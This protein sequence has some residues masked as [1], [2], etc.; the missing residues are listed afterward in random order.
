MRILSIDGGGIRGVIPARIIERI[1]NALGNNILNKFDFFAGTST[2]GLLALAFAYGMQPEE[3]IRMYKDIGPA[4]FKD[5]PFDDFRD[6]KML[7]G[8]DYS[9]EP[10]RDMLQAM[11]GNIRLGDLKKRVLISSFDLD[12]G[13][14]PPD[15]TWKPKFF[16]NFGSGADLDEK[17]VDVAIRTAAAPL[18]FPTYQG[19]I[20][21]GVIANNPSMCAVAAALNNW[22]HE[23]DLTLLSLG[24]GGNPEYISGENL[25]WGL[26]QWGASLLK[27]V[28]D[29]SVRLADYQCYQLLL[30]RYHRINPILPYRMGLDSV[31]AIPDML[32]VA[33]E[34][35]LDQV[36]EWAS[37]NLA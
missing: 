2:G 18:F 16:V 13:L 35:S 29:G 3:L 14:Q 11:F 6:M 23:T 25:N 21:G 27:I 8:A 36:L 12:N 22:Y 34:Y 20:D 31:D 15:R 7:F 5:S 28:M 17:I 19:Y 33:D 26:V 9:L 4:I 1:G 37:K 30:D 10:L 32:K 24:C